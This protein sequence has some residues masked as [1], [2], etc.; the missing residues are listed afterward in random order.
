MDNY[1]TLPG[2]IKK[3]H[4]IGVGVVGTARFQT[5]SWPPKVLRD[6]DKEKAKFNEFYYTIDE[7]GILIFYWMDN[8]MV[9]CVSTI[10]HA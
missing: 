6:I 4:N 2:V 9:F 1:F 8:S 10:H 5:K 3:L 7:Y